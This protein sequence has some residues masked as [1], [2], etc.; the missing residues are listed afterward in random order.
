M[1][2]VVVVVA[3]AR[4]RTA[5]S[6]RQA[7]RYFV[8]RGGQGRWSARLRQPTRILA[9]PS[10]PRTSVVWRARRQTTR[11][12]GEVPMRSPEGLAGSAS[13]SLPLGAALDRP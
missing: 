2:V 10:L 13:H 4:P 8:Q 7:Q 6:L 12:R 1:V 9:G 11:G 3:A 5:S